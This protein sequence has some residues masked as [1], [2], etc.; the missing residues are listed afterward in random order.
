MRIRKNHLLLFAIPVLVWACQPEKKSEPVSYMNDPHSFSNP[1]Q[2][3]VRHL[4]WEAFIDFDSKVISATATFDLTF[5]SKADTLI[6]DTRGL[7]ISGVVSGEEQVPVLLGSSHPIFGQSLSIPVNP[8]HPTVS[9]RYETSP[10]AGALQWLTAAQTAGKSH[11]FLFTQSQAILARTWIPLQDAPQVRFTYSA[12][13][14]TSNGLRVLMSASNPDQP[15]SSGFWSFRMNQPIPSYLMALAAGNLEFRPIDHRSGVYAEPEVI[16]SASREFSDTGKMITAAESLYGPYLW[17]RYDILMLPPSF[18]FGGMENPRLTFATPTILAGDKSLVALVAH[19]LAHSWSGNLVTNAVWDDFWLNEG[20]TVY[21][22]GRIMEAVYGRD[23]AVMEQT[24]SFN[25]LKETISELGPDHPDTRL[26]L[27]LAGRDPDEGVS[28]I[29]YEKGANFLRVCEREA[30]RE[31]WDA[32]LKDYFTT[33]AF[34]SVTTEQFLDFFNRKLIAGDT[35]LAGRIDAETWIYK[36]GIPQ[37]AVVYQ[38]EKLM[39]VDKQVAGWASGTPSNKLNTA[40]WTTPEWLYFLRQLPHDQ[41]NSRMAELDKAF[42]FSRSGN[43]EILAEWLGHSIDV[44]YEPAK[45]VLEA[46]LMKV[47]R[48]KFL[49]P[50]YEKLASTPEGLEWALKVYSKARPGYHFV[51]VNT[52]D[53]ILKFTP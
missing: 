18:P 3:S 16:E 35:A 48:R 46:F 42:G 9:I 39:E 13:V 45:P 34:T 27:D 37:N 53:G 23:F 40:S 5:H 31:R 24:L 28:D 51:S 19:E 6:L 41:R 29:A 20:F 44:G 1:E 38:S 4:D 32:F 11:P 25:G 7:N 14:K 2:V 50:L 10:D 43:S 36:P 21:F 47:G 49:K 15:D 52:I 8:D 22:E 30:G 17:D 33:H 26:K 12:R